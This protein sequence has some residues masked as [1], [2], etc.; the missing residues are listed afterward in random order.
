MLFTIYATLSL[1]YAPT[2]DKK[3]K[4]REEIKKGG[5]EERWRRGNE[6]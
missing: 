5:R 4:R 6:E 3:K 2:Q 1:S